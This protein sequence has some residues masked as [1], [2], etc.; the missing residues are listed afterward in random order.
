MPFVTAE[1]LSTAGRLLALDVGDRTVGLAVSDPDRRVA[2]PAGT[3]RRAK[4]FADTATMLLAAVDERSVAALIVGLPLDL[5]GHEG[6]RARRVR[7][8]VLN[9]MAHRDLPA[10]MWDERFSTNAVEHAMLA[11][12]ASRRRRRAAKDMLAAVYILQGFLDSLSG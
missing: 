7:Q 5:D 6:R 11:D 12:D 9:L 2:S 8:F 4:R 1:D 10:L 3:V